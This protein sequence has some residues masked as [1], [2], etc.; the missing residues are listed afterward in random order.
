M[1]P[2]P[3]LLRLI[4]DA[5]DQIVHD[6]LS[7]QGFQQAP[8]LAARTIRRYVCA[9]QFRDIEIEVYRDDAW[10]GQGGF[11]RI[12]VRSLVH[13]V[14]QALIG[15]PQSL[16]TPQPGTK[17]TQFQLG[18]HPD[19]SPGSW[20]VGGPAEVGAFAKGLLGYLSDV[21]VPWLKN[22]ESL[23]AVI[24]HLGDMQELDRRDRLVEAL[25][26]AGHRP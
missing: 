8:P 3:A 25:R 16:V 19:G 24:D 11:V 18:P 6:F 7:S 4:A 21:A 2:R 20:R 22:T 1:Q 17:V 23:D 14:Q 10:S 13:P 15:A 12:E 5:S 9:R 26:Q